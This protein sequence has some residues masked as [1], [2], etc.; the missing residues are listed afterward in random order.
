MV[1]GL[2]KPRW[3]PM[4]SALESRTKSGSD[5]SR[6]STSIQKTLLSGFSAQIAG[7]EGDLLAAEVRP[8]L[9][10]LLLDL[11][12]DVR[13]AQVAQAFLEF[14][15]VLSVVLVVRVE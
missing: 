3:K 5:S 7:E 13:D 15:A 14:L 9:A 11:L 12:D 10:F 6:Q 8:V 1:R 4:M 2:E